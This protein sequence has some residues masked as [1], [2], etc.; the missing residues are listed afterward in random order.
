MWWYLRIKLPEERK[1]LLLDLLR[2]L[3][4]TLW[5]MKLK[6]SKA[7]PKATNEK[8]IKRSKSGTTNYDT[9]FKNKT[10]KT[11]SYY[12]VSIYE[13]KWI[14]LEE[15]CQENSSSNISMTIDLSRS[16]NTTLMR[17]LSQHKKNTQIAN[18]TSS[19]F[20]LKKSI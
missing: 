8:G 9:G 1:P 16:Q 7:T 10:M 4:C 6:M 20:V 17:K 13:F 14:N 19:I 18:K 15:I 3:P 2:Y 11:I 5:D 12:I